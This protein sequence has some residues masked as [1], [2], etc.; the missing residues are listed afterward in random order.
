MTDPHYSSYASRSTRQT[1][2][3]MRVGLDDLPHAQLIPSALVI[4]KQYA[5]DIAIQMR[6][7][8]QHGCNRSSYLDLSP[9]YCDLASASVEPPRHLSKVS[10]SVLG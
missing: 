9:M 3:E 7:E 4:C 6:I 5:I 2:R 10:E 1:R 8:S